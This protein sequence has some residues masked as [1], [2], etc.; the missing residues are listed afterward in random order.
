MLTFYNITIYPIVNR[1]VLFSVDIRENQN[2]DVSTSSILNI[3]YM[4]MNYASID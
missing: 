4:S 2:Y 1:S 3:W